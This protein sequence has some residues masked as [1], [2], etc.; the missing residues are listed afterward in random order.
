MEEY[1]GYA[2]CVK[3]KEQVYFIGN[4]KVS[5][6]GR[7][8]AQGICP[9]CGTK[10]NCI[11]RETNVSNAMPQHTYTPPMPYARVEVYKD[12]FFWKAE[13]TDSRRTLSPKRQEFIGF[14]KRGIIKEA[15]AWIDSYLV[16][17]RFGTGWQK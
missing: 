17:E 1:T 8:M 7:R 15:Q 3:C 2:Y 11:L 6:S 5:D 14:T 13:A 9:Q 12:G 4:I 10:V 16:V